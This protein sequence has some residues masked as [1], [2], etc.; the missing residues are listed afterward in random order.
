[1]IVNKYFI[2]GSFII[3]SILINSSFASGNLLTEIL[4]PFE[5]TNFSEIY[6]SY[7]SIIDFII[8]VILFVGLSQVTIGKIFDPRGGKAMVVA[9]GLVLAIG[10]VIS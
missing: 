9:I 3:F 1:M 6:D 5:T 4:S 10:L 8:Y 2:I 7:S